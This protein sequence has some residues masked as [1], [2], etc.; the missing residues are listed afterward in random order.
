M[1]VALVI[2][3]VVT[4][5]IIF[6]VVAP[7]LASGGGESGQQRRF[8]TEYDRMIAEFAR[9][10]K[11]ESELAAHESP[12]GKFAGRAVTYGQR[13]NHG[14]PRVSRPAELRRRSSLRR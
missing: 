6:A 2:T 1:A 5:V 14:R 8:A 10:R 4:A 12:S 7:S 9:R 3:M 11:V 13:L